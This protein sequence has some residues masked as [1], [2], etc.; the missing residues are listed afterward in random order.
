MKI[1]DY[2]LA[3]VF[4]L[5]AMAGMTNCQNETESLIVSEKI[6]MRFHVVREKQ[7]RVT[8]TEFE[9]GDKVSVY[10]TETGEP[11]EIGG[12]VV[13]NETLTC[14]GATW[15]TSRPLYWDEGTYNAYAYYPHLAQ[16]GSITDF[17]FSIRKNQNIMVENGTMDGYEASDFLYAKTPDVNARTGSVPLTFKHIM[18]KVTLRLVKGEDYEGELP[19]DAKLF[20]HNIVSEATIDLEAGVATP[21]PKGEKA[22]IQ[23]KQTG[24]NTFTAIVVPQRIANYVPLAEV[25]ING[26]SY[27]YESR[28][29]FKPGMNHFISLVI[30]GNPDQ[31]KI[32]IGGELVNQN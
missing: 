12:N 20:L 15:S 19:T 13:N 21:A 10:V 26:V 14:N 30:S 31:I 22:I 29:L 28:F 2:L 17:P 6:P 11:L 7:T 8:Q 4:A 5:I 3:T 23:A 1:N 16:V 27:L 32:E 25:E 18:S 9:K 24:T